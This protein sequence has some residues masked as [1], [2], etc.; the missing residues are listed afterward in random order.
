MVIIFDSDKFNYKVFFYW[1]VRIWDV[2]LVV[3]S[4][5]REYKE[6]IMRFVNRFYEIDVMSS[7]SCE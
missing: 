5:G 4:G 2:E 7:R 3:V 6:D 1:G